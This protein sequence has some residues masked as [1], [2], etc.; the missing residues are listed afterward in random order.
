MP[1]KITP[2]AEAAASESRLALLRQL[3]A[4]LIESFE[5]CECERDR[6]PIAPGCNR[7]PP[8]SRSLRTRRRRILRWMRLCRV[9][10]RGWRRLRG[11]R[12]GRTASRSGS[13]STAR[14]GPGRTPPLPRPQW[15]ESA[16][17]PASAS[18]PPT[19]N[20]H[21]HGPRPRAARRWPPAAQ[22][23]HRSGEP[24]GLLLARRD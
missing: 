20:T 18:P 9:L 13:R 6:E 2:L 12:A 16:G 15:R 4:E 1:R 11:W 23:A 10:R 24:A 17:R 5:Q 3:R 8:K 21:C 14:T 7:S 19:S 22:A